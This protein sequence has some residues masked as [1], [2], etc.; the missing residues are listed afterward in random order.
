MKKILK[1]YNYL[2]MI[3]TLAISFISMLTFIFIKNRV[4]FTIM[5][6]INIILSFLVLFMNL[7]FAKKDES[8]SLKFKLISLYYFVMLFF[9]FMDL[10]IISNLWDLNVYSNLMYVTNIRLYLSIYALYVLVIIFISIYV[11]LKNNSTNNSNE[12]RQNT[13][14]Q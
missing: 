4:Y 2:A 13:T 10:V 1:N 12:I 3:I 14:K 11:L 5:F 8:V 6:S 9:L 7:L